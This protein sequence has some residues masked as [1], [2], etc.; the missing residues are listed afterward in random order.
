VCVLS[1]PSSTASP[2]ARADVESSQTYRS[3]GEELG[4]SFKDADGPSSL[5]F[6]SSQS[7]SRSRSLSLAG[8]F[9]E[10]NVVRPIDDD[11]LE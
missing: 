3:E 1:F 8:S 2:Y 9:P 4:V 10:P 11:E 5:A 7:P 6:L